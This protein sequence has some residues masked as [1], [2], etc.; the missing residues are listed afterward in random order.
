MTKAIPIKADPIQAVIDC[1]EFKHRLPAAGDMNKFS[2]VLACI[3]DPLF[4]AEALAECMN[5]QLSSEPSDVP[6]ISLAESILYEIQDAIALLEA[7]ERRPLWD[8]VNGGA[9]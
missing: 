1:I 9:K 3:R 6:S 2:R 4:R 5:V 8:K 7:L